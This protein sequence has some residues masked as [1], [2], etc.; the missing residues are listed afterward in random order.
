[1][2][3]QQITI[4]AFR[5]GKRAALQHQP[6]DFGFEQV[7]DQYLWL[8]VGCAPPPGVVLLRPR[9]SLHLGILTCA[10]DLLLFL[11]IS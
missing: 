8:S 3:E 1:M 2:A 7:N 11:Y 9:G 5:R 6:P 10:R 4:S